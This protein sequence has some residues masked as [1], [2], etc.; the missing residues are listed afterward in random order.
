MTD[1]E[2]K[3]FLAYLEELEKKV[4]ES[5]ETARRF[6]IEAGIYTKNGRLAKQYKHLY[7]PPYN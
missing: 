6:L 4:T 2:R 1:K 3:E 7:F 5:K